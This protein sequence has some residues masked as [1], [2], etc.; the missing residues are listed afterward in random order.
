M[1]SDAT[2]ALGT[3][4]YDFQRHGELLGECVYRDGEDVQDGTVEGHYFTPREDWHEDT[5]ELLETLEEP[6]VDVGCGAGQHSV[7]LQDHGVEVVAFDVSLGAVAA[8]RDRGV[9]DARV[10]DVFEMTDEFPR[11]RFRSALV[12]GTQACLAG[13]L[14]G[15]S[16]LLADLARV[17]DEDGIAV[18]DSYVPQDLEPDFFGYRPDPRRGICH[19]TMHFE[20]ERETGESDGETERLVGRTLQ[21]LLFDPD[22]LVEATIGTPWE[23]ERVI[24]R[25]AFYKAI[26]RKR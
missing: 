11:D 3:A 8:A 10:L 17:T 6:V 19:R 2:D 18:V 13:S 12:N 24:P 1:V 14:A 26:L 25:T 5:V 21:F 22:R 23:L 4:M 15:V 16:A 7:W 9:E 20:Y